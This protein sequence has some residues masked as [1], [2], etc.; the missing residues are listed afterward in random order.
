MS[1]LILKFVNRLYK[2]FKVYLA[3][4]IFGALAVVGNIL[5]NHRPLIPYAILAGFQFLIIMMLL[6]AE[7]KVFD[8]NEV[9]EDVPPKFP[10]LFMVITLPTNI[11]ESIIPDLNEEFYHLL[12]KYG[13][14]S[15]A[16][17]YSFQSM[18]L[19][20]RLSTIQMTIGK[21]KRV[22]DSLIRK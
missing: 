8:L 7:R 1:A 21:T 2:I 4:A 12:S 20:L 3:L 10:R 6:I 14:K 11:S 9:G 17:W 15:A 13:R 19:V 18:M 16:I 5:L 22:A